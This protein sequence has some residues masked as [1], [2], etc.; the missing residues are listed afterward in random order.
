[1]LPGFFD[2]LEATLDPESPN[3]IAFSR[4]TPDV[5]LREGTE[6]EEEARTQALAGLLRS[7]LL[8]R[9]ESSAFALG[10]TMTKMAE[11]HETFLNA[12][13]AGY[14]VTTA[15]MKELSAD[16]EAVFEDV[17]VGTE[18]RTEATLYD[19]ERLRRDV[20]RDLG[21]LRALAGRATEITPDRDPKLRALADALVVIA[22]QAESEA[23]DDTDEAQRRKVLIFSFFEDTVEW[24]RDFLEEELDRKPEMISYR[25]RMV[26]VSGSGDLA[27]VPW[28]NAV[29]GFAPVSM[30]ACAGQDADIYDLLIATDVLAEG[31]N[32]QQCRHIIN[33]DMPWNPMPLV[34]RHGRIDRIGSPHNRVFLHTIFPAD[35]LDRLLNLEQR[36]LDKLPWRRPASALR[37]PLKVQRTGDRSSR[38]R[39]TRLRSS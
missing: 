39:G 24:I 37:L 1:M 7:G 10:K 4:Y 11:E 30:G 31:V 35:R 25:G 23:T 13:D 36:I 5:Y 28:K 16:D 19:V 9:F 34:Q 18:H 8:K 12:L 15:F 33:F 21:L 14:V 29:E 2:Q 20:E 6:P 3:A 22:R 38:R 32:L 26:A 27:E 17:L